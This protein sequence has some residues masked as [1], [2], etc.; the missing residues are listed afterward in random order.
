ME[1]YELLHGAGQLYVAPV[2]EAFPDLDV[3]PAGNWVALGETKEGVTVTFDESI[4]SIRV[5]QET[6]AVKAI[7]AE[8]DI[9]IETALAIGTLENLS[10][11]INGNS[12]T[13]TAA[14]SGTI[15]TREIALYRGGV[16]Q[17][18]AF[19]FRATSPYGATYPAQYE[20][21]RGYFE[22]PGGLEYMKDDTM[23]I[24]AIFHVMVDLTAATDD[25]K[26]GKLIAQDADALP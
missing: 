19:L 12:V 6:G 24:P 18:F 22:G 17:E 4:E 1:T 16:V 25:D 8:E 23:V 9:M 7:R 2:G 3:T 10:Y 5:D 26:F 21:P 15:G 14:G 13:D 20:C 11:V